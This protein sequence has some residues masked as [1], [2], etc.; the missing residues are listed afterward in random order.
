MERSAPEVARILMAD[1]TR[2]STAV[3]LW[4]E[5][6]GEIHAKNALWKIQVTQKGA[7]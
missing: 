6:G 5:G 2:W 3:A 1:A 4:S 7:F